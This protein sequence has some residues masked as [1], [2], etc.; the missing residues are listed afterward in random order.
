MYD[1]FV[2]AF[3]TFILLNCFAVTVIPWVVVF[4]TPFSL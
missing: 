1:V 4:V 3:V 2:G